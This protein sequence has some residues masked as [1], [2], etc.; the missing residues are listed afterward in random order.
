MRRSAN[1][2]PSLGHSSKESLAHRPLLLGVPG[3]CCALSWQ[4]DRQIIAREFCKST[5]CCVFTMGSESEQTLLAR[6]IPNLLRWTIQ[7]CA[8]LARSQITLFFVFH[9]Y[10]I[11]N[12]PRLHFKSSSPLGIFPG[13]TAGPKVLPD[14]GPEHFGPKRAGLSQR[15]MGSST[16]AVTA[17][18]EYVEYLARAKRETPCN[19][20]FSGG[21]SYS[22][23]TIYTPNE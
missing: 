6:K 5:G 9:C 10:L 14:K 2:N 7:C 21:C 18:A 19:V 23:A 13:C 4:N 22:E 17:F 11:V 8:R 16:Q 15:V 1:Q 12:A 3:V 20:S